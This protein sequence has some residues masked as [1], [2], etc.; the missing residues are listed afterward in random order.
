MIYWITGKSGSGKTTFAHN[1]KKELEIEEG[2]EVL[3]LD[4]DEVRSYSSIGYTDSERESHIMN[5]AAFASIAEKQG[6]IVIIA[7][8]SPKTEWRERARELFNESVL[9]YL[10]GGSLWE[11]T[12]Y[13]VPSEFELKRK[14][15]DET[16]I[17]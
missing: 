3:L 17:T 12:V 11:G 4:G 16:Q 14:C 13:E 10:S 15:K 8:L 7:L 5:I 6:F 2:E 9:I 1:L